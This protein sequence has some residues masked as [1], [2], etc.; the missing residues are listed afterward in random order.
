MKWS[1]KLGAI[2]GIGVYLHATFLLLLAWV[3]FE[4]YAAGAGWGGVAIGVSFILLIFGCVLLHELGHALAARRY[5]IRTRDITLLPIGGVAR[6]ERMPEK[7][8]EEL[9]VALA[10]PAVNLLIAAALYAWLALT[11]SIEPVRQVRIATGNLPERLLAVN[12]I[13]V[14]FNLLPAF[15]MD[16]GRVVRALFATRL[17]YVRATHIAATIGQVMAFG[18]GLAGLLT[19]NFILLFIALFVWIGAA[20]EASMVDMKAALGGIPVAHAMLTEF[21]ALTP[22]QP[23]SRATNLILSGTQTDFPVLEDGRIAGVLTRQQ[24]LVALAQQGEG[25]TVGEAMSR[26]FTVVHPSDMLD[27]A[28]RALE[29]CECRSM[30]VEHEG[31]L[32]GLLTTDNIGEFVMIQSA[33]RRAHARL[34][35]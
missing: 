31:R 14:F 23:L 33:L 1:W 18:F 10:G 17:D 11:Q 8:S 26:E 30:P 19:G 25:L 28:F 13:L 24:L 9:V 21:H 15:P 4:H 5:G 16:G 32:V 12:L 20:G 35:D 29:S 22:D 3:G 6:L 27:Q 34:R 2:G 7:P